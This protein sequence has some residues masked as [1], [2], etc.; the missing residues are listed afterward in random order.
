MK[1]AIQGEASSFHATA[2]AKWRPDGEYQ[3]VYCA[4]FADVFDQLSSGQ[5]DLAVVAVAN[6]IYGRIA[7]TSD[8]IDQSDLSV[9]ASI[10]L[11]IAQQL[12][13]FAGTKLTDIQ[14]VYSHPVALAQCQQSLAKLLPQAQLIEHY[15]TSGAIQFIKDQA[16]PYL[17]AIASQQ[18]AD[19]HDM[20]ILHPDMHDAPDNTTYFVALSTKESSH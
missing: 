9:V 4:R 6:S 17:A 8:F 12:I 5:V 18:A 19:L 3:L 1:I 7:E 2:V 20:V 10:D 14:A 16:N 11:P 15:D 13:G